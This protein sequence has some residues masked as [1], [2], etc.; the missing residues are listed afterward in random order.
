MARP[1]NSI[2]TQQIEDL[3]EAGRKISTSAQYG[4]FEGT[5][6]D[7]KIGIHARYILW[8]SDVQSFLK[9]ERFIDEAEF[10]GEAD[11]VPL[12]VP[13]LEV[14]GVDNPYTL[15]LQN[16][17]RKEVSEKL[18]VLRTVRSILEKKGKY[19]GVKNINLGFDPDKSRLYVQKHEIK[20]Q[21]FSDQY[22]ALRIIFG[23][24]KEISKEWFFS[25]IAELLNEREPGEKRYYNAIY[26]IRQK[27][28]KKGFLD[29]FISTRQSVKISP[30]YLS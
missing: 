29:F 26:Q 20:I 4:V 15:K 3:I 14:L 21:K 27:V 16:R 24:P 30:K 28:E 23:D 2:P 17:I 7:E 11:D 12:L 9:Q 25:E 13:V 22:H 1:L 8:K 19:T 18:K 6:H 5:N 10:F